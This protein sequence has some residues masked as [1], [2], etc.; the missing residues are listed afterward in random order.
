MDY[1]FKFF[2]FKDTS[3]VYIEGT[4]LSKSRSFIELNFEKCMI[5]NLPSGQ[6]CMEDSELSEYLSRISFF[7]SIIDTKINFDD[8]N[9]PINSSFSFFG[10]QKIDPETKFA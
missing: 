5:N 3:Q 2:C 10:S 9:D 8:I 1:G 4:Q 7:I 6:S